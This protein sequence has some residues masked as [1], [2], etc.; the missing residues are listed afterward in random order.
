[1]KLFKFFTP[2]TIIMFIFTIAASWGNSWA[3]ETYPLPPHYI[4]NLNK[5]KSAVVTAWDALAAE[6]T[7]QDLITPFATNLEKLVHETDL[8]AQLHNAWPRKWDKEECEAGFEIISKIAQTLNNDEARNAVYKTGNLEKIQNIHFSIENQKKVLDT[9]VPLIVEMKAWK[10]APVE[11]TTAMKNLTKEKETLDLLNKDYPQ[12]KAGIESLEE[13][14]K[15]YRN[16]TQQPNNKLKFTNQDPNDISFSQYIPKMEVLEKA[17]PNP[18]ADDSIIEFIIEN[19]LV[20]NIK[21]LDTKSKNYFTNTNQNPPTKTKFIENLQKIINKFAPQNQDLKKTVNTFYNILESYKA[22]DYV[23][24]FDYEKT[25]VDNEITHTMEYGF[26]DDNPSHPTTPAHEILASLL[27]YSNT[28]NLIAREPYIKNH[29]TLLKVNQSFEET[30]KQNI[31]AVLKKFTEKLNNN[32]ADHKD[33]VALVTDPNKKKAIFL[34]FNIFATQIASLTL[35]DKTIIPAFA[36]ASKDR[37]DKINEELT[38]TQANNVVTT[39][40]QFD[41]DLAALITTN[42]NKI[43][44]ANALGSKYAGT[45]NTKDVCYEYITGTPQETLTGINQHLKTL[46]EKHTATYGALSFYF[47]E[48]LFAALATKKPAPNANPKPQPAHGGG[49][50]KELQ[51][52]LGSLSGSL[53]GL[54]HNLGTLT[55]RLTDLQGRL[56]A[57]KK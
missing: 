9:I 49:N 48:N 25:K 23:N 33:I 41:K 57:R 30:F 2:Q 46:Q 15:N 52:A 6:P 10:T 17:I 29:A 14:L 39:M 40:E 24:G 21:A 18:L 5:W 42:E 26:Y 53:K 16:T 22:L 32:G 47:K 51:E 37:L 3:A 31:A 45:F 50:T 35:P 27:T 19:F 7:N 8:K 11:Y 12:I 54:K 13:S 34:A 38:P 28:T 20:F 55:A 44:T 4:Q 56:A 1:M 36:K 43:R